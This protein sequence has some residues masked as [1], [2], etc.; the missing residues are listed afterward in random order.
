MPKL[1]SSSYGIESTI[2][3]KKENKKYLTDLCEAFTQRDIAAPPGKW[4][5]SRSQGCSGPRGEPETMYSTFN[6]GL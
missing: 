6:Q 5:S 3:M 4:Y 2:K 1:R